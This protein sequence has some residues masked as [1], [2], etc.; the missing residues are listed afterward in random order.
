MKRYFTL[1]EAER[2][3]PY[4]KQAMARIVASRAEIERLVGRHDAGS[5]LDLPEALRSPVSGR[6][7]QIQRDITGLRQAGV[8]VKC[9]HRGIVDLRSHQGG[10]EILLCWR[11]GEEHVGWWHGPNEGFGDRRLIEG[12]AP[13]HTVGPN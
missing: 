5:I 2:L 4:L 11:L 13:G 8:L 12:L 3:L 7:E 9:L 1:E 6:I 10:E